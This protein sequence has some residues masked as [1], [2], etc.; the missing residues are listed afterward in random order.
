MAIAGKDRMQELIHKASVLVEALP[1]IRQFEK[2]TVVVKYGGSAMEDPAIRRL[3]AQDVVLMKYVGMNPVIV[4]GGGPII[5]RTLKQLNVEPRFHNGLRITDDATIGVVEM[6]L[7]G[8]VN[9]DIVNL[10]NQAGGDAVGLSGKDGNLLHARKMITEDGTDLG[11]V[12]EIVRVHFRIIEVLC[13][14]GMIPV[15]A[16]VAT[17]KE[18]RTWNVNADTAAGEIAAALQAEK[19]VFLTDT[20]GLLSDLDDQDSLIHQVTFREVEELRR[21][22]VIAGGMIPKI[23]ACHKALDYGVRQTHII[24]GRVPHALL[25]EIFTEKGL[26]TLVTL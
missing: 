21:K 20:A 7:A 9:K 11:Q 1:Y 16:P 2:K 18:G 15:I 19:L 25:L 6:V 26:G 8:T 22:G 17:D 5:S 10:I 12:G 14:E 4:H 3:T 23:D 13:R 24:D